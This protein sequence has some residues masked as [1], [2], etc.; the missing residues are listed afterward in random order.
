MIGGGGCGW[1]WLT[2]MTDMTAGHQEQSTETELGLQQL[3]PSP[4][5]T[6]WIYVKLV[7]LPCSFFT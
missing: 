7:C 6:L 4:I 2:D 1:V 3:F 5:R